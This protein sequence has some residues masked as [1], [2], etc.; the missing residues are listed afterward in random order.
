[1]R[2]LEETQP[3]VGT[4]RLKMMFDAKDLRLKQWTVTDAQGFDTSVAVSNLASPKQ[5]D[6]ELFVVDSTRMV[7]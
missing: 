6:Q 2:H 7:Q 4:N 5:L 1:M 3:L